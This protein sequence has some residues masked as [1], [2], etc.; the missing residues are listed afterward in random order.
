MRNKIATNASIVTGLSIAERALGFLYR[1]VLSRLIG[2]EGLGLYQVAL[3]LFG[4]FLTIGTGGLPITVSRMISK[5]K[6]EKDL[7]GEQKNVTAGVVASLLLTLPFSILLFVFGDKIP[8]LFS[9]SRSFDVFKI[10][11]LGL[12]LSSVYAI[13]RGFFWGNK[14]FLAPSVMEITEEA[15]M[16]VAGILLLRNVSSAAVGAQKAAWAVVISYVCSFTISFL[17]F[18]FK[19]GKFCSPKGTLKPLFSAALPI[20]SVRASTSLVSS[21]VAVL[22]PAML[23]RSGMSESQALEAFGV[24][25]GMVLPIL[26]IPS[27]VIGSLALVLV[28]EIS[29]DFYQKNFTRLRVNLARGLKFS[30]F[31]ACLLI[32][33]IFTL[34]KDL[35]ALAYSNLEAGEMIRYSAPL[36]LP[37]SV[38]MITTA[39]LNSMGFEKKTFL[40][41]FI[42]A[43]VMFLCILFLPAVCGAYAYVIGLGASYVVNSVC[44]LIVFAKKCPIYPK[45]SGRIFLREYLPLLLISLPISLLGIL[46]N[47]L[48]K[49]FFNDFLSILFTALLLAA[50]S[51][52]AYAAIGAFDVKKLLSSLPFK[53]KSKGKKQAI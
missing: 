16:V 40:F 47:R 9:D 13:F 25:S 42:S 37:M 24:V 3:S 12:S 50:V 14:E 51:I 27:T 48:F 53:R 21:A 31:V 23:I 18:F 4:L 5:S 52:F 36:L 45:Q 43:A 11:I 34:G 35:G 22:L 2:A 28:P 29:E 6:A 26:F 44:N 49:Y 19:K 30:V 10:L 7:I 32:P 20:T 33:F 38:T 46:S 17:W 39:E 41:F 1:V 15:V 8:F